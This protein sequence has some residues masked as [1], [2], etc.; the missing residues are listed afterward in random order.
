MRLAS[1]TGTVTRPRNPRRAPLTK[2]LYLFSIVSLGPAMRQ[3][4]STPTRRSALFA[5]LPLFQCRASVIVLPRHHG[6][7]DTT[8]GSRSLPFVSGDSIIPTVRGLGGWHS[9][10]TQEA[11]TCYSSLVQK[12]FHA[13]IYSQC[14]TQYQQCQHKPTGVEGA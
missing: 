10:Q 14:G 5:L 1:R 12:V 9:A 8:V 2:V 11:T 6:R 13:S 7:C 4:S 3:F